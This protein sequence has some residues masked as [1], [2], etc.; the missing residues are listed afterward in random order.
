MTTGLARRQKS[1]T[2]AFVVAER[3]GAGYRLAVTTDG[4]AMRN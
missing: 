1:A 4:A 2:A 3:S